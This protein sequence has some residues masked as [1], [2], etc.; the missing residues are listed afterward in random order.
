MVAFSIDGA[1]IR[2]AREARGWTQAEL[3]ERVGASRPAVGNWEAG[4][5]NPSAPYDQRLREVLKLGQL[6]DEEAV[7]TDEEAVD[8][9]AQA[10]LQCYR[11]RGGY[12]GVTA[13]EVI[14]DHV[15]FELDIV[16]DGMD[17]WGKLLRAALERAREVEPR[18]GR[19]TNY[20]AG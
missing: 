18:V 14:S 17:R 12:D 15:G 2:R 3:A 19:T 4:R 8:K 6:T 9:A 5:W 11:T 1:S 10:I 20:R 16:G 13:I 7:L